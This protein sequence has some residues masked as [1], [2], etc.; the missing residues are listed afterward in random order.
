[1]STHG[2]TF[3]MDPKRHMQNA[4]L[5]FVIFEGRPVRSMEEERGYAER[6]TNH[7]H[8]GDEVGSIK[9]LT[10]RVAEV[11]WA[12]YG[13][14]SWISQKPELQGYALTA[15]ESV[16]AA[17]RLEASPPGE[18]RGYFYG[19]HTGADLGY[20]ELGNRWFLVCMRHPYG[21]YLIPATKV[22]EVMEF[23]W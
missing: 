22:E 1:M 6:A 15:F 17:G 13:P 19:F 5:Q 3:S 18:V 7:A 10:A 12:P 11:Y 9:I 14:A 23:T 4:V 20:P 2:V 21:A 16:E 8:I